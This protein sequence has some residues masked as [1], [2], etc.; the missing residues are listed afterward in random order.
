MKIKKF[1]ILSVIVVILSVS[2]TYFLYN[3]EYYKEVKISE[4][5]MDLTVTANKKLYGINVDSDAIHFGML[6]AGGRSLR[7]LNLTNNYGYNTFVFVTKDSSVLS[8]IVSISPNYF[9]LKANENKRVNVAVRVPKGFEPGN[10]SCK[11]TVMK[12]VPFFR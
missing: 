3:M 7:R 11:V 1:L 6:P 10:Y 8:S 5:D 9:V 2:I 4:L 12:R